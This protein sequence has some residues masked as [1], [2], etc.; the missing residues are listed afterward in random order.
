M[1]KKIVSVVLCVCLSFSVVTTAFAAENSG[2]QDSQ[3]GVT[4]TDVKVSGSSGIGTVLADKINQQVDSEQLSAE[5]VIRDV[6]VENKTATVSYATSKDCYILV[7]IHNED[8]KRLLGS[9]KVKV[10]ADKE[11]AQ[12]D[13]EISHMPDY[14]IIRGF[15]LD[16]E[17][18]PLSKKFESG[19]YTRS[20]QTIMEKKP[21][22]YDEER[23]VYLGDKPDNDTFAVFSDDTVIL[24]KNPDYNIPVEIDEELGKYV[25]SN[26]SEELLSMKAGMLFTYDLGKGDMILGK[27]ELVEKN[28]DNTATV[29]ST[30]EGIADIFEMI[31]I[32]ETGEPVISDNNT[33]SRSKNGTPA[34]TGLDILPDYK[35]DDGYYCYTKELTDGDFTGMEVTFGLKAN[36][37]MAVSQNDTY[38]KFELLYKL[39]LTLEA[40][41][42]Y[43][44]AVELMNIDIDL[45]NGVHIGLTPKLTVGGYIKAEATIELKAS[46]GIEFSNVTGL[47][48]TST[49]FDFP[50]KSFGIEAGIS[51]GLSYVPYI[52]FVHRKIARI[53]LDLNGSIETTI[54]TSVSDDDIKGRIK[55]KCR[56]CFRVEINRVFTGTLELVILDDEDLTWD[57]TLFEHKI[58]MEGYSYSADLKEINDECPNYSYDMKFTITKDG[59]PYTKDDALLMGTGYASYLTLDN[60]GCAS[61]TLDKGA[62]IL[63]IDDKQIPVDTTEENLDFVVELEDPVPETT[64]PINPSTTPTAP[65]QPLIVAK[66]TC[67]ENIS[68]TLNTIGVLELSGSGKMNDF[69]CNNSPWIGYKD[70]ITEITVSEGITNIS[71]YSFAFLSRVNHVSLPSTITYIGSSAFKDCAFLKEIVLPNGI[72]KIY[73]L[74]FS[75]CIAMSDINIPASV[76][77]IE[78]CAFSGCASLTSITIPEKVTYIGDYAFNSCTELQTFTFK[79]QNCTYMGSMYKNALH[80]CNSLT[81]IVVENGVQNIPDC[82]FYGCS[83]ITEIN[84]PESLTK[85]G[86]KAF[87]YCSSLSQITIPENVEYMGDLCFGKCEKISTVNFNAED[88]SYMGEPSTLCF[89]DSTIKNLTIGNSVKTIPDYAFYGFEMTNVTLPATVTYIGKNSFKVCKKLKSIAIPEKATNLGEGVFEGC[90]ELEKVT[91]PVSVKAI[92]VK[93]FYSCY[94]LT[95]PADLT[96]VTSVGDYAFYNC[97][98][99]S[100]VNFSEK[101]TTL[102]KGAF[103]YCSGLQTAIVT[104]TAVKTLPD[105]VFK[106]CTSLKY[107]SVPAGAT[108]IGARAFHGCSTLERIV[109]PEKIKSVGDNAY[110]GCT[111]VKTL[112]FNA[113]NCT[114]M[115]SEEYIALKGCDSLVTV[116]FGKSVET[117]PDYTFMNSKVS[118]IS[119]PD[120]VKT[121]GAKAFLNCDSITKITLSDNVTSVGKGAFSECSQ[122]TSVDMSAKIDAVPVECF[123]NCV[124]LSTA[125]V[126]SNVSVIGDFA[127]YNCKAL[128]EFA[129]PSSVGIYGTSSFENCT[130]LKKVDFTKKL[131][132]IRS[133]AFYQCKALESIVLPSGFKNIGVSAFAG[134]TAVKELSLPYDMENIGAKAFGKCKNIKELTI[135]D[136]SEDTTLT[137]GDNAFIDCTGLKTVNY[138]AVYCD[139]AGSKDAPIFENCSGITYINIADNVTDIPDYVFKNCTAVKELT[140]PESV[141]CIGVDACDGM[142]SLVTVHIDCRYAYTSGDTSPFAGAPNLTNAYI[143]YHVANTMFMDCKAL[144]N[145]YFSDEVTEIGRKAFYGTSLKELTIPEGVEYILSDAL[146]NCKIETLNYN[147]KVAFSLHE[148]F[149]YETTFY[150]A[151]TDIKNLV[152]DTNVTEVP[153]F[154]SCTIENVTIGDNVD[155]SSLGNSV[156]KS[157]NLHSGTQNYIKEDH[158]V[159]TSDKTKVVRCEMGYQEYNVSQGVTSVG[160]QAFSSLESGTVNLPAGVEIIEYSAFSDTGK[161]KVNISEGLKT[162]EGH[163]FSGSDIESLVLPAGTETI[164]Y[165]AFSW[166]GIRSI[167]LPEGLKYIGESAF[168]GSELENVVLPSGVTVD[169]MAFNI[170]NI[171]NFE[172]GDNAVF[173][174]TA[175]HECTIETLKIGNNVNITK[176][177]M[178]DD[179]N[180]YG[181]L[182]FGSNV[183]NIELIL[184]DNEVD[185]IE[186]TGT[187]EYVVEDN[188][189]YNGDK[190][191]VI[192]CCPSVKNLVIPATVTELGDQ[193]FRKT[194]FDKLTIPES[195]TESY[196]AFYNCKIGTLTFSDNMVEAFANPNMRELPSVDILEYKGTKYSL[197]NNYIASGGKYIITGNNVQDVTVDEVDKV[198]DC[199][200]YSKMKTLT[201]GRNVSSISTSF[202]HCD[203][204]RKI[205]FNA[206]NCS[207]Y[208]QVLED[209]DNISEIEFG[210]GVSITATEIYY[211]VAYSDSLQSVTFH[212]NTNINIVKVAK[213]LGTDYKDGDPYKNNVVLYYPA[214]ND[215]W[216]SRIVNNCS[217]YITMVPYYENKSVKAST[218]SDNDVT[219]NLVPGE[220]Y[221]FA[222]V[223]YIDEEDMLAPENLLYIDQLTADE[224]GE[225]NPGEYELM[226]DVPYRVIALGAENK[227]VFGD[228]NRDEVIDVNDVTAL[229]KHLADII[230]LSDK[231]L[232][233]TDTDG[234]GRININDATYI[235]MYIAHMDKENSKVGQKR[236]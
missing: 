122:L 189:L 108:S 7:S 150:I 54:A 102:G 154:S 71:E 117:I 126:S 9:G 38:I 45:G 180:N 123:K 217:E 6:T 224:N 166:S 232:A 212:G 137:I 27:A 139:E 235:Q 208:A 203:N 186:Y 72:T 231:S 90:S 116:K 26:P 211:L 183:K 14:F 88:C 82:A 110:Y 135:P 17:N 201:I 158:L 185:I 225:I 161:I 191:K 77:R 132:T 59:K 61:V 33:Y 168:E 159:Y 107:A 129:A 115:G 30:D 66:G 73:S 199:F 113:V 12:V 145:V 124:K 55:H 146:D 34:S 172:I 97:G 76:E 23:V 204:L 219:G 92:P 80:D 143:K 106:A 3:V 2:S 215:T 109:I 4:A 104:D 50:K 101:L 43:E 63:E 177:I 157:I 229:Q 1:I 233:L 178:Y 214:N 153:F 152:I 202:S 236:Y 151:G 5:F 41:V 188:V 114:Y 200:N 193:A 190:T 68:W 134:C 222:A 84:L 192:R 40:K 128:T 42:E 19:Y 156:I 119:I 163:A 197:T 181:S 148:I 187:D 160:I 138:N 149:D 62:Y 91:L 15:M 205:Y 227:D 69:D 28:D 155:F 196:D 11:Q 184:V 221:V 223:R 111:S 105:E 195:V 100:N 194:S 87:Y 10:S 218:G 206:L 53:D 121:I 120:L 93:M 57:I 175:L 85:I 39:V 47:V 51:F 164:E 127:F 44:D 20:I 209:C 36:S 213:I 81:N 142:T 70:K 118:G 65:P 216:S 140:F 136:V 220:D 167:E 96:A 95:S 174:S 133:K 58:P 169:E 67:G 141:E 48:D 94:K 16:D 198:Y 24:H 75:G 31:K 60:N 37:K 64:K 32:G 173:Y 98:V 52:S 230:T 226:E 210:E 103:A 8:S 83:E 228:I 56:D 46:T 13:I 147:A 21:S 112:E 35:D 79:A 165:D 29:W 74:A 78:E 171:K 99:L 179:K 49:T 234:N 162:I 176:G 170:T 182:I 125:T 130:A 131:K 18:K 22:D 25:F 144:R 89:M 207:I 86:T